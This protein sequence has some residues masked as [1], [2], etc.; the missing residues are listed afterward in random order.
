MG[1]RT[2]PKREFDIPEPEPMKI[3]EPSEAPAE[4]PEPVKEP[5]PA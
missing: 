2:E 4:A 3:P 5:V 1:F